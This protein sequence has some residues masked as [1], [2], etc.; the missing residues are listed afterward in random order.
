M[1]DLES[2]VQLIVKKK[3]AC[4]S[5]SSIKQ[6]IQN[7]KRYIENRIPSLFQSKDRKGNGN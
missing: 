4:H 6:E 2:H 7:I 5:L 3:K 1:Y